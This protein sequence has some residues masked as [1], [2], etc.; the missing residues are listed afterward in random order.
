[1]L[2]NYI[3]KYQLN[4]KK[5]FVIGGVGLIGKEITTA[6]G[7]AGAEVFVLDLKQKKKEFLKYFKNEKRIHFFGFN[8]EKISKAESFLK[9]LINL[10]GCPDVFVNCSYPRTKKWGKSSFKNIIFKNYKKNIHIHLNSY[11]WLSRLIGNE[12]IKNKVSG[13]IIML[14]SIYGLFG[15]DLNKYEKTNMNENMTYSVIKSGIINFAR[16]M[17]SYYGKY[18][19]RVNTICPGG[20]EGHVAE[21]SVKQNHIFLENYVKK[22]PLKRMCNPI[23]VASAVLFLSSEASSYISGSNLLIDGGLTAIQ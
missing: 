1:M 17:C 19:I 22:V 4:R 16:Q 12:M 23:D 9:N 8:C 15:Q 6:L 14:S 7:S 20:L 2:Q 21:I 5:A 11:V 10:K 3:K 13:S 18:D